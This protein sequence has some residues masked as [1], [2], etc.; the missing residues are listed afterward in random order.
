MSVSRPC[1]MADA[2]CT[3]EPAPDRAQP[4]GLRGRGV[5]AGSTG[6]YSAEARKDQMLTREQVKKTQELLKKQLDACDKIHA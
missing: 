5:P 2:A 3:A 1:K 6:P 4:K